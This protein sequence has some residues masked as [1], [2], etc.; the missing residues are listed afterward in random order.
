MK[1]IIK[2]LLLTGLIATLPLTV[3]AKNVENK[4]SFLKGS[5]QA[6]LTGKFQG[7]DDVRYRVFAKSGQV[8]KFNINSY[9]NLAYINV[10]AP[11]KKPG[12]DKALL[13]GSTMGSSGELVLPVDGD[14]IIQVYQMRNSARKN[15]TVSFS[16]DLQILNNKNIK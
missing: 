14:Y 8:L 5:D 11:G 12:K 16:L 10:F 2:I 4:V 3:T 15:R 1:R 7:Y 9:S 6:T 13:V